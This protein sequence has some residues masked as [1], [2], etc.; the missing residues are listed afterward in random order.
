MMAHGMADRM[1]TDDT[2]IR[3]R[4]RIAARIGRYVDPHTI[5]TVCAAVLSGE[6][7]RVDA[8][9]PPGAGIIALRRGIL[10]VP[11]AEYRVGDE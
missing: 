6:V 2:T 7:V 8:D 10:F 9:V 4:A 3:L 1:D 5:G 11:G